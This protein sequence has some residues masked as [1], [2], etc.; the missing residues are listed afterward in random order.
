LFDRSDHG[1]KNCIGIDSSEAPA[2]GDPAS[3][4][5]RARPDADPE[6]TDPCPRASLRGTDELGGADTRAAEATGVRHLLLSCRA[7]AAFG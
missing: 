3:G 6:T 2:G 4:V 7:D 5:C 1:R